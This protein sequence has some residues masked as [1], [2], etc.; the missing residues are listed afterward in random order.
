M[1]GYDIKCKDEYDYYNST[2]FVDN[3]F[4]GIRIEKPCEVEEI[5]NDYLLI[6]NDR[7]NLKFKYDK[8]NHVKVIDIRYFDLF[9]TDMNYDD[10]KDLEKINIGKVHY[11]KKDINVNIYRYIDS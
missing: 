10:R 11:D 9:A 3:A 8:G 6:C 4:K 2:Y 1:I 5:I 7:F